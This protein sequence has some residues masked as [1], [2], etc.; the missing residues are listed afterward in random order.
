MPIYEGKSII[1]RNVVYCNTNRKLTLT[2]FVKIVALL[3]NA[4]GPSLLKLPDALRE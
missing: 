1:I 4:L 3:F 2:S